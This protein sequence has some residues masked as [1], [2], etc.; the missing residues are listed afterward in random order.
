MRGMRVPKRTSRCTHACVGDLSGGNAA[1]EGARVERAQSQAG[2]EAWTGAT[3]EDLDVLEAQIGREPRGVMKVAQ[4]CHFGRPQV[5]V[6][7]PV[8][9]DAEGRARPFPTLFW[10]TCP[11][12]VKAVGALEGAGWID[13]MRREF[14]DGG[15]RSA[16]LQ[17]AHEAHA[18]LRMSLCDPE[19]LRRLTPGER[20]VVE[21]SGVGG[22]RQPCG[23]KCLHAHLAD[24]LGRGA[25]DG[26]NV[27][28]RK[29]AGLLLEQG[30]DLLG[31]GDCASCCGPRG[32]AGGEPVAAIDAGSNA[33]RLLVAR[34]K[35]T[36]SGRLVGLE[37]LDAAR[38]TTR[39]GSAL[40]P[41]GASPGA[42][43][44]L[45]A[46]QARADAGSRKGPGTGSALS[47]IARR[48][49]I[50]A[51]GAFV[52][53]AGAAGAQVIVAGA[54][55]AGRESSGAGEFLVEVWE[56]LGISLRVIPEHEEARLA[57]V[58]ALAALA[59]DDAFS[60][61]GAVTV[62][63]VGGGSTET[64]LG[65]GAGAIRWRSSVPI[66]AVRLTREFGSEGPAAARAMYDAA[67]KRLEEAGVPPA[68]MEVGR[69]V[70]VGG[71]AAAVAAVTKG[72]TGYDPGKIR[73][74]RVQAADLDDLFTRLASLSPAERAAVPGL[75]G[76][77]ADIIL[78]GVAILKALVDL[79]GAGRFTVSDGGVAHGLVW[80]LVRGD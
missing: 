56:R 44:Q 8:Q 38:R 42:S 75:D 17:R 66:G 51:L 55:A 58:G 45:A 20:R 50:D 21:E 37:V 32:G 27:V 1:L 41:A 69:V 78:A 35:R 57:Y 74:T 24:Y 23:I 7:A 36:R 59:G 14:H 30:I 2:R 39:L 10:L 25:G 9:I 73:G 46:T 53:R 4:R 31:H 79:L 67:R 76:E 29:T 19:A 15:E 62:V 3:P 63:D 77:R 71:T 47:E 60:E 61:A 64:V 26:V 54:T 18:R 16:A 68:G 33:V 6:N 13:R 34:A 22:T 80:E 70:A 52:E 43:G 11:Y 40:A 72:L 5:I 28:G 65:E 49:T 12:L 48:A